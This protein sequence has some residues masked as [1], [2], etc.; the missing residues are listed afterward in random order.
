MSGVFGIYSNETK[1]VAGITRF[2][3]YSLQH[4]GQEASGIAVCDEGVISYYKR[5]L[6]LVSDVFTLED[7]KKQQGTGNMAIGHV[8]YGHNGYH[9]NKAMAQPL[10]VRHIKGSMAVALCGKLTNAIKLREELELGGAIFH[11]MSD[12]EVISYLITRERLTA[13]SI[14][15]AV[16]R[17]VKRLKGAF[18]LLVMSPRKMVAVRDTK[19]FRPLSLGKLKDDYVLASET[20]TIDCLG[21]EFIRDIR[22]GEVLCIEDNQLRVVDAGTMKP[23][24][25]CIF[26]YIYLARQDSVIEG[27]SVHAARRMA[28][29]LL[30]QEHPVDADV[31]IGVPES[32]LDA[33][34]GYSQAT[35]IDYGLGFIKNRYIGR[36]FIQPT[37]FEREQAVSIKLNVISN[38]VYG[39]RVIM[40]DDSIVRG[41]T[42][43]N[44]V[45]LLRS[46]GAA[47]VHVRIT[48]PPFLHPCYFGTDIADTKNLIAGKMSV[49]QICNHIGADSLAFLSPD[50]VSRIAEASGCNFCIGCFN[51]QYP[52]E[53]PEYTEVDKF[54]HKL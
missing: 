9:K 53:K 38:T 27:V 2:A 52:C 3:L 31:V 8:Y 30:A 35:G 1:D 17:A 32:G 42:T 13:P 29:K 46:A 41:T 12:A 34:I 11:S 33:A 7:A 18:S 22:P 10:V 37:H 20:C 44:I 43:R 5:D 28:G 39:K 19:G 6:G 25:L 47:E 21:A 50:N 54:E 51:G 15:L 49:A 45:K 4:R 36:T 14:E 26:E 24:G 23:S 48:S 40:I 16:S